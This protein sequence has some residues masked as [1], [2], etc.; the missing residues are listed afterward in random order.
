[1][2]CSSWK[3]EIF[4]PRLFWLLLAGFLLG[5]IFIVWRIWNRINLTC[6]S[7]FIFSTVVQPLERFGS[8]LKCLQLISETKNTYCFLDFEVEYLKGNIKQYNQS[9]KLLYCVQQAQCS[10]SIFLIWSL[11]DIPHG[12]RTQSWG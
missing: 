6:F 1:M 10:I 9:W 4:T 11:F 5:N 8:L 2:C 7:I 3:V 12:N